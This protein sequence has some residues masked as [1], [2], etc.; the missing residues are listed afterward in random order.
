MEGPVWSMRSAQACSVTAWVMG[1]GTDGGLLG[2]QSRMVVSAFDAEG[3]AEQRRAWACD[4]RRQCQALACRTARS[5][6]RAPCP[7]KRAARGRHLRVAVPAPERATGE[8]LKPAGLSSWGSTLPPE[9]CTQG[10]RGVGTI[11]GIRPVVFSTTSCR[12]RRRMGEGRRAPIVSFPQIL[13]V[14]PGPCSL[15][16]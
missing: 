11:S 12:R 16:G 15:T 10:P 14:I 9:D 4:T 2:S 8:A 7:N 1:S 5:Q 13:M 3:R 6:E